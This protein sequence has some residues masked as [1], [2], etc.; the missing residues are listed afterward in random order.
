MK[1][2]KQVNTLKELFSKK[3]EEAEGVMKVKEIAKWIEG[4]P[5]SH[6]PYVE[7]GFDALAEDLITKLDKHLQLVK[8]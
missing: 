5:L 7:M 8:D 6:L 3:T 2:N 4:L 1:N